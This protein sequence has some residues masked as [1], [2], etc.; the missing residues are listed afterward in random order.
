M[1]ILVLEDR[2]EIM[3]K[4]YEFLSGQHTIYQCYSTDEATDVLKKVA[5]SG[6]SIDCYIFDLAM[7]SDGLQSAEQKNESVQ[8]YFTGWVWIKYNVLLK[9]ESLSQKCVI[10]SAYLDSFKQAM[11][12]TADEKYIERM[13]TLNKSDLGWREK[14]QK[15]LN[16]L[17]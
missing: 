16:T 12:Q 3:V 10:Y 6:T 2:Q 9:N 13:L 17:K 4:L 8:G 14:L 11:D 1:Q 15:R 5:K 7:E